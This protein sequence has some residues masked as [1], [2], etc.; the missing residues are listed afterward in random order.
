MYTE[1]DDSPLFRAVRRIVNRVDPMKLIEFGCPFDEYDSEVE[2]ILKLL[3][4]AVSVKE[5]TEIINE[6]FVK[7][8]SISLKD[9]GGRKYKTFKKIAEII[10]SGRIN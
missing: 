3:P 4:S 8:F 9:E 2:E 5:L 10:W 6:I 7:S 1:T